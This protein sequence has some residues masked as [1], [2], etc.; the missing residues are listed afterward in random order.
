MS[1]FPKSFRGFDNLMK[2]GE[3]LAERFNFQMY[4]TQFVTSNPANT[5]PYHNLFHTLCMLRNCY[6]GALFYNLPY[7]STRH[8]LLAA[9][10]HD[11]GHSG[12]HTDDAQNVAVAIRS[13][14]EIHQR[15]SANGYNPNIDVEQVVSIIS[16]TQYPFTKKPVCIE[17]M[18]IRDS[19]V[20]QVCEPEWKEHV[21]GGLQQELSIRFNK[22]LTLMEMLEGQK[23]FMATIEFFT[24][25]GHAKF[26]GAG[27]EFISKLNVILGG[28]RAI[29][30]GVHAV[31]PYDFVTNYLNRR[32]REID[33]W[34]DDI[35]RNEADP[36]RPA[37]L[38]ARKEKMAASQ[39]EET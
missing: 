18:L 22:S 16:V 11:Y 31:N 14:R 21:I 35:Q 36:D 28:P 38:A 12:G 23:D 4:F 7:Q 3:A 15:L 5:L 32:N 27:P 37:R 26:F 20:L 2:M 1:E 9:L 6:H 13:F 25:W 33:E 19:D 30:A 29:P 39:Q 10:Y 8:L 24:D 17:E 34:I